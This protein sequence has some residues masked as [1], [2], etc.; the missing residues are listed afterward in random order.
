MSH[1]AQPDT[2]GGA[3]AEPGA[4]HGTGRLPVPAVPQSPGAHVSYPPAFHGRRVSWAAVSTVWAGFI[5][6]GIALIV[7]HAWWAFWLGVGLAVIGVLLAA[8]TNI[9]DDW[10]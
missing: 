5:C 6:G 1:Q 7:G 8:A 4:E 3:S 2:I 10:Y 9:F